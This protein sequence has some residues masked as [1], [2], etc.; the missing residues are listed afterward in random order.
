MLYHYY[1]AQTSWSHQDSY[2]KEGA[3][4]I[5]AE[6]SDLVLWGKEDIYIITGHMV[7]WHQLYDFVMV[8]SHTGG[9]T[10]V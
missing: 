7:A 9:P 6:L 10:C 5:N 8:V 1:Q 2:E 4:D 3:M